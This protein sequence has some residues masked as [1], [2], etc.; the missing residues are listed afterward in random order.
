MLLLLSFHMYNF[1]YQEFTHNCKHKNFKDMEANLILQHLCAKF[2]LK[3]EYFLQTI[4][5]LKTY[6]VA[7]RVCILFIS[8]SG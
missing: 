2:L 7:G 8:I 1:N 5:R 6:Y 4:L 3:I